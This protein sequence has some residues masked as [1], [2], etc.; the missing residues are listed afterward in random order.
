MK[1]QTTTQI[2]LVSTS[3]M[4]MSYQNCSKVSFQTISM[5]EAAKL[6]VEVFDSNNRV[7]GVEGADGQPT[8]NL[9]VSTAAEAA[10]SFVQDCSQPVKLPDGKT[11]SRYDFE[12]AA[13]LKLAADDATEKT[14][15]VEFAMSFGQM[16]DRLAVWAHNRA[17][18]S[19][20]NSANTSIIP[21]GP[22]T[23]HVYSDNS[24]TY[25]A[26]YVADHSSAKTDY[27]SGKNC[28]FDTVKIKGDIVKEAR[29][30]GKE[31][32]DFINQVEKNYDTVH[33]I[34]Y[35]M[36]GWCDPGAAGKCADENSAYGKGNYGAD[37]YPNRLF[38]D[39]PHK[40]DG[41][42]QIVKLFVADLRDGQFG[43][44]TDTNKIVKKPENTAR[45]SELSL[46]T[47]NELD[48]KSIFRNRDKVIRNL[49][50]TFVSPTTKE[51]FAGM[52]GVPQLISNLSLAGMTGTVLAS[53]YTP[54]VL[55]LGAEKVKT[56]G[57]F[58]GS[59]FNMSAKTELVTGKDNFD[60]TQQTAWLSGDL[61]NMNKLS[62]ASNDPAIVSDFQ[63]QVED[64]FL[65]LA[66][67][68][69][70][71]A[72]SR[73]LFGDKTMVNGKTYAN[74]FEA[75]QTLSNKNCKSPEIKDRYF[76][77][78]DKNLY[79]SKVKVWV[80]ANRNGIVDDGEL[81]TLEQAGVVAINA[82]N[83]I[84]AEAQD[85]F[86]NGTSLRSAF[87]YNDSK[88][89]FTGKESEIINR[90]DTGKTSTGADAKFRLAIDL[91]FKVNE[92]MSL[93]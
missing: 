26:Y 30:N 20:G 29:E 73:Q 85:A 25:D 4:M 79:A 82:C 39:W 3:V 9:R 54:I 50:N 42:P 28:F 45:G 48:L 67:E 10:A 2:L 58:A 1:K 32:Y 40:E 63:R 34:H 83:V 77:P 86:G 15:P 55:D 16:E 38:G 14:V 7:A 46:N 74:G 44:S 57:A 43:I 87:L 19:E 71:V 12:K 65:V 36:Y 47:K 72:S 88:E 84:N 5:N 51:T 41:E 93:E 11:Q 89:N 61:V 53:Q 23:S 62:P 6:S 22:K 17:I 31:H 78:W 66:D 24:G 69:G 92:A 75:L 76:G 33:H 56:S 80:D 70:Q 8:E 49:S 68:Q 60:F 27:I 59:F 37:T 52:R 35:M 21:V 91:I 18:L 90:L 64:G 13:A 81:K